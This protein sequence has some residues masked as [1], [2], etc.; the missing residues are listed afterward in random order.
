MYIASP[1][2]AKMDGSITGFVRISDHDC[3]RLMCQKATLGTLFNDVT[4]RVRG[5]FDS[6][7]KEVTKIFIFIWKGVQFCEVIY[8]SP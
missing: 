1:V 2:I 7:K 4:S 5:P 8:K 3:I 6:E